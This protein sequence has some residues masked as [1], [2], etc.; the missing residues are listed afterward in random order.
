MTCTE[1]LHLIPHPT[2]T[3]DRQ[4]LAASPFEP[5]ALFK[6]DTD[7]WISRRCPLAKPGKFSRARAQER[8]RCERSIV[9]Q[10]S[11]SF[12]A[13]LESNGFSTGS[14]KGF[15]QVLDGFLP[16]WVHRA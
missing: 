10:D 5:Q 4:R 6:P 16:L 9:L 8:L 7:S 15:L 3:F 2:Q 11:K 13:I 1:H 12:I 14:L